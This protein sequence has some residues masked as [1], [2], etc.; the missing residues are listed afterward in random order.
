MTTRRPWA[1]DELLVAFALYCRIP[2]GVIHSRNP[3][4]VRY[5]SAIGR[6]PAALSMK[7]ANIASLDDAIRES[8]RSGLENAS[9]ADRDMWAE[10]N[11]DWDRFAVE[12]G[13]ALRAA[14]GVGESSEDSDDEDSSVFPEGR[15]RISIAK[16]RVGHGFFRAA[17]RSAY[18][19]R[20]CITG[21]SAPSLLVASHIVPWRADVANRTNPKNGLLLSALHDR[22]FDRGLITLDDD[23]RVVVSE[24]GTPDDDRFFADA[25]VGYAG[26]RIRLPEKFAPE[27]QFLA[28]H[29]ERV[30]LG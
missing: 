5:A 1:R 26:R 21:L 18:D 24:S 13:S 8:G 9:R 30:F 28:Y 20:C 27:R 16:A 11:A 14:T 6:T 10:M 19:G 23:L 15:D 3:E 4:I 7:M 29:R 2:F 25:V 12:S 22:A 17:V